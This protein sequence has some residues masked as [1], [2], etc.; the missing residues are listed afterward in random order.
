VL[1]LGA[2]MLEDLPPGIQKLTTLKELLL[3]GMHDGVVVEYTRGENS[4]SLPN[5]GN[6]F[7]ELPR[8]VTSHSTLTCLILGWNQITRIDPS[9]SSL[10]KLSILHL[11]GYLIASSLPL[12]LAVVLTFACVHAATESTNCP[13]RLDR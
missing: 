9:I 1:N 5:I 7:T 12:P 3:G 2:N 8:D 6:R 10:V 13:R 4:L 11:T